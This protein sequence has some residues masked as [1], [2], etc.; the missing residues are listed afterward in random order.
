M[1]LALLASM[2]RARAE[3]DELFAAL[4]ALAAASVRTTRPPAPAAAAPGRGRVAT[5]DQAEPGLGHPL[6][7][8]DVRKEV[9]MA[10]LKVNGCGLRHRNRHRR[11][12]HGREPKPLKAPLFEMPVIPMA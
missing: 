10:A 6:R 2:A 12:R 1:A 5:V 8:V 11:H 4:D 7:E 9:A 3:R